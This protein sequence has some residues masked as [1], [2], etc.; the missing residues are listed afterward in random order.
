MIDEAQSLYEAWSTAEQPKEHTCSNL[1]RI[2]EYMVA[3]SPDGDR[4]SSAVLPLH[5]V[6]EC[7]G[8]VTLEDVV[9]A[10]YTVGRAA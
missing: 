4:W 5:R 10:S 1:I 9:L 2:L 8:P 6:S 3:G 7:P